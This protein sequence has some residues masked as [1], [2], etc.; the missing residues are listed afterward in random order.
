VA[1]S[2][3]RI[4]SANLQQ[5]G[6]GDDGDR[7]RLGKTLDA[8]R[9]WDPDVVLLQELTAMAPESLSSSPWDMW[10]A[11]RAEHLAT[12]ADKA[13]EATL[14][15]LWRMAAGMHMRG[16]LGP[17]TPMSHRRVHPAILIRH[18]PATIEVSVTGPPAILPGAGAG[19]A[20]AEAVLR[21]NGVPGPIGVYAVHLP[22][23][24]PTAQL[25]H[26]E[27]LASYVAGQSRPAITGGDWSCPARTSSPGTGTQAD[28]RGGAHPGVTA[29][30]VLTAAGLSDAA[31]SLAQRQ[32]PPRGLTATSGDGA[33]AARFHASWPLLG[34][35]T[36]YEQRATGG[37]AQD[38]ILLTLDRAALA[39]AVAASWPAPGR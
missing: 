17:P 35:V 3:I 34:A 24:S 22:P 6:L 27:W 5:G 15:H 29:N 23:S 31:A 14:E 33:R 37:A 13:D 11:E 9:E 26:A 7:A 4:A 10:P 32:R 20:W 30:D 38:A 8:L 1:V 25:I 36:G 39:D 19:P 12:A 21:L 28:R 2:V 16:V 18:D